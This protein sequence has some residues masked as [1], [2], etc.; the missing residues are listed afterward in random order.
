MGLLGMA[1]GP[2]QEE[3][4]AL[5]MDFDKGRPEG[6]EGFPQ[7]LVGVSRSCAI[8]SR[9]PTFHY[10][11]VFK[12]SQEGMIRGAAYSKRADRLVLRVVRSAQII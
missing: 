2:G 5:R 4:D 11:V 3:R 1:P 10:G 6:V 9:R 8:D 7:C 12:D